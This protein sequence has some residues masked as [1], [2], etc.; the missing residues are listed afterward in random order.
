MYLWI[1]V[2]IQNLYD[3]G[4]YYV[5]C[6]TSKKSRAIFYYISFI[7][8]L[9]LLAFNIVKGLRI[10]HNLVVAYKINKL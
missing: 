2:N 9:F 4:L 3:K 6:V 7:V 8:K 5:Q 1:S 10:I